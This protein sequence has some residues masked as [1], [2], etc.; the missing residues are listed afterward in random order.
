MTPNPKD[1]DTLEEFLAAV[2][3]AAMQK[4]ADAGKPMPGPKH[5]GGGGP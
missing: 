5:G 4:W 3:A 2:L 1:F